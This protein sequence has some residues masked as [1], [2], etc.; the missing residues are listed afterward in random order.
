MAG[1]LTVHEPSSV[2]GD[3]GLSD[4]EVEICQDLYGLEEDLVLPRAVDLRRNT[5]GISVSL[6]GVSV[7]LSF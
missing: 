1:G 5:E 7:F 6:F 2:G 4:A 3:V